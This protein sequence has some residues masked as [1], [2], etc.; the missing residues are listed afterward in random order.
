[1]SSQEILYKEGLIE[2]KLP[3]NLNSQD[4]QLFKN[5]MMIH[6]DDTF[7]VN[8]QEV[9]VSPSGI[10]FQG[11]TINNESFPS[12][13]FLETRP[14]LK[15][16]TR[17][18]VLVNNLLSLFKPR[19]KINQ[20]VFWITDIWSDGYFHWMSDA[21]P[22]L[23]AIKD[24]IKNGTLILPTSYQKYPYIASSLKPFLI[25]NIQYIEQVYTIKS[26]TL[27]THLAP[28]GNYN[29]AVMQGLRE[30]YISSSKNLDEYKE[31]RRVYISRSKASR[32]KIVNEEDCISVLKDYDFKVLHLEDYPFEEQVAILANTQCLISN[33]GA[34]LTNLLFMKSNSKVLELR[35]ENDDHNNCFFSLASALNV[36]YFYQLCP[37]EDPNEIAHTANLIVDCQTLRH[38]IELML[39][40]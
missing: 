36:N 12:L 27:S 20:E 40:H 34:G 17:V 26:L 6:L 18:R 25:K 29:E 19:P 39:N 23:F 38:N 32:R 5:A 21:L 35:K 3:I 10:I 16:K 11:N 31:Y 2:R 22:R 24:K 8:L 30:L 4:L 28:T 33:H 37:T 1:M 15:R 14:W 7:L 9:S 13:D